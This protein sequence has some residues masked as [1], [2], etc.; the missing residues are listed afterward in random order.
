ML[1]KL[2]R[3]Q[4]PHRGLDFAR[5]DRVPLVVASKAA[6]LQ[7]NTLKDV[8]HKGVHD[9]HGLVGDASVGVNLL[10]HLVDKR[11][12]GLVVLLLTASLGGSDL[13]G[14]LL[15]GGLSLRHVE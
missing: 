5:G 13:L 7:S 14:G 9:G 1:G 10:Q 12:I 3:E 15:L 11:S 4:K 8:V 6:G 2:T